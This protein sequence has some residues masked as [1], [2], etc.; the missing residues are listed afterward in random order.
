MVRLIRTDSSNKDFQ[1][2]VIEL[3][4]DLAIR[5]GDDHPFFAQYNKIDQIKHVVLAYNGAEAVGCGAMKEYT[6][7][8]MEVKRM[9]VPPEKRGHGIASLILKELEAWAKEMNYEKC[10]LETGY[11]QPEAI[12]LY[13]KNLYKVIPNY[14]QYEGVE[15]SVCFEKVLA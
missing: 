8:T 7:N 15:L 10:I 2:L 12:R 4:K 3:D 6:A 5:D 1:Q 11:A 13:E 14:G 9:F